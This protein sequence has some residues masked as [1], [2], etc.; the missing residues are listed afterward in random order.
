[1]VNTMWIIYA[2]GAAFFS[3]ITSVFAKIGVNKVDTKLALAIRTIIVLLFSIVV[4]L[5]M[6]SFTEI[7]KLNI[8]TIIFLILSGISTFL[9]WLTYFKALQLGSINLVTPIDKTSIVL[10]LILSVIFLNEKITIAKIISMILIILGT[11]LMTYKKEKTKNNRWLLYAIYTALFASLTTI[12]G[13]IGLNNVEANF[14]TLVR[15]IIVVII[16]WFIVLKKKKYNEIKNID[17]K[18]WL[19]IVLSGVS[20]SFSWLCYF[21]ALKLNEASIVFPIEKFSIVFAIIFSTILLKE[22]LNKKAYIGLFIILLGIIMLI[23]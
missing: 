21:N 17:K 9:L 18:S 5:I 14:A 20:T 10:T 4:V 16:V 2:L 23:I 22:K 15:T 19:S 13:K 3:G 11:F 6:G 8:K 12:L 1:M 7:N